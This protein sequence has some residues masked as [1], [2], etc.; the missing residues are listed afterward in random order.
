A[1][2]LETG[3]PA[4]QVAHDA[5]LLQVGDESAVA[6]W[7]DEV[8]AEHPDEAKRYLAGEKKLQGVLVGFVMKKSAGKAD[9][10]RVNQLLMSRSG[11]G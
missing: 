7:I 8:L 4:A 1:L 9:P 10:K 3:K 5:S 2:M 6:G 11:G